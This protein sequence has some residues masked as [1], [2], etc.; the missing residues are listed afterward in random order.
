MTAQILSEPL[1]IN[2]SA[3][4][5]LSR[6]SSPPPSAL[7]SPTWPLSPAAKARNIRFAQLTP[8]D[9]HVPIC[10]FVAE[11]ESLDVDTVASG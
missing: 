6:A 7:V 10:T 3:K 4:H 8:D 9:V 5:V 1:P 11:E 2:P